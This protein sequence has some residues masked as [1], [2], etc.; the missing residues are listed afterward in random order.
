M[1][2]IYNFKE[3]EKKITTSREFYMEELYRT[4]ESLKKTYDEIQGHMINLAVRDK[5]K[6]WNADKPGGFEFSFS[7]EMLADTGDE[8]INDL[9]V[10]YENVYNTIELISIRN[11]VDFKGK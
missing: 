11:K 5:W 6:E 3:H 2:K 9:F 4:L 8:N 7:D 10:L 1:G